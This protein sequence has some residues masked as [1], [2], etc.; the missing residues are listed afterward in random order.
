M[1]K[2]KEK[3]SSPKGKRYT[4]IF[5]GVILL[6]WVVFRFSA[7]GAEKSLNV[8]NAARVAADIGTPVD[9]IEV[10]K[11]ED[12]IK[13]PIGIKNNRAYVSSARVDKL[14]SGQ[15]VGNGE[16]VSVSSSIDLDTGMHVVRTRGASDGLQYAEFVGNG[17]FVPAYA[18]KGNSVL[19]AENGVAA[20]REVTVV[21]QDSEKAFIS[22]G[23]KD[24]DKVILS[25]VNAG[26]K[27]Q[28]K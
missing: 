16:I 6:C 1:E 22:E 19:I 21:R 4:Y 15:K 5:C 23:L 17:Y 18:V 28:V 13:E 10:S 26:D 7:I 14:R 20:S 11:T 25:K 8:F 9:V 24:G 3:V 12:I 2:L 27:V